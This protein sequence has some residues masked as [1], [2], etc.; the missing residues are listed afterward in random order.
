M[1][2]SE[3][4][5]GIQAQTG[6]S[7][8]K[9]KTILE[10]LRETIITELTNGQ[11]IELPGFGNFVL[12]NYPA[13]TD[14]QPNKELADTQNVPDPKI[15]IT[16][17]IAK[18]AYYPYIDLSKT[19]VPKK[20]L[21]LIPEHIA[22]Y[23]QIV[24]IDEKGK[25]ISVA[26]IDPEDREAV[27]I[28][29]KKTGKD[30]SI[31]IC[32]QADLNHVLD[33]YSNMS[34]ELKNI[35]KS[36]EDEEEEI[37]KPKV[38]KKTS[39]D[40]ITETAPAAKIV[41][42]L[43]KRA[44]REKASDIH[45]EAT[46]EEVIVR[47]RL[48]GILRKVI[49]LPIDILP[50]IVSRIKIMSGLKIDET[51]L[52]QDGRFQTTV[53][54]K[55]VDFRVS[56]F[57]TVNGEK[58]VARI[59]DKSTGIISLESLGLGKSAFKTVSDNISKAHG[60]ILVT[61]PTG[62]GKTTSLYAVLQK[63]MSEAVNI[64]TMEDPVEYHIPTINQG[65]VHGNIG[66]TFASGLR[67]I[68]RQ[69]P[70]VIMVGEIRDTETANMAVHAALT[71]HIVLSTLHTNDAAGAIPRFLDMGIEP[72]LVNSSL[73]AIIAQRLVRKICE[74]CKEP[75]EIDKANL[76]AVNLEIEKLPKEEE[77]PA[78]LNFFHG[79]GCSN[80]GDSGYKGRMGIFEVLN[81]TEELKK[82]VAKK[83]AGAEIGEKAIAEG[84]V[85]MRQDGVLKAIS[86]IT[87]LEEVWRVTKD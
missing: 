15:R 16:K 22:R 71:G 33:Q 36:A 46:E 65:Q 76:D 7:S 19:T 77:R 35:V 12:L 62:S 18:G 84:M 63:L 23:W 67:S 26:M 24:P 64:V 1:T 59:L 80:C 55:E 10:N 25:K 69:D 30:L 57:P 72:F 4:I 82:L 27:E 9:V 5:N 81:F 32:T 42:S 38:A 86:G 41:Q 83:A 39:S 13:K 31:N 47:F 21:A 79:K 6:L 20:I 28:I 44:V 3:L 61:G 58:V 73:N 85:T 17:G 49:T 34:N 2:N 78:K 66:F 56:T 53:D 52:P 70:D 43:I 50:A 51:R 75:L 68:L 74:N 60:M 54:G 40:E 8:D 37:P 87:T 29:K 45:V 14:N 11:E 48:D